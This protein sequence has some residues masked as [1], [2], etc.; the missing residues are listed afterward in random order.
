MAKP[1]HEFGGW[2]RFFQVM[3][4]FGA[5]V[6]SVV[7]LIFIFVAIA[8]PYSKST[9]EF[10]I[11]AIDL[12]ISLY[13][14]IKIISIIKKKKPETPDQVVK[15][16]KLIM[17]FSLAFLVILVPTILWAND[18]QWL[19]GNTETVQG[20][21]QTVF[22]YFIWKFYFDKSRRVNLY[23]YNNISENISDDDS[24]SATEAEPA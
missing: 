7:I 9:I 20:S 11:S 24:E 3:N 1:L 21:L 15:Y 19:A 22:A 6:C 4:I 17:I 10:L 16:L 18:G 13:F 14:M 2:L 5:V 23:Y 8:E 12:M